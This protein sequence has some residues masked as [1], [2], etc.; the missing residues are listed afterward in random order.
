MT[1]FFTNTEALNE[2]LRRRA[3]ARQTKR[4]YIQTYVIL[5]GVFLAALMVGYEDRMQR[6]LLTLE[7]LGFTLLALCEM[8]EYN[9]MEK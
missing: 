8:W 9:R 2:E 5:A 4:M 7:F 6:I 3:E 1:Q